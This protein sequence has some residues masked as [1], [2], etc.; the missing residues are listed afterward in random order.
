MEHELSASPAVVE[1]A[2]G[3]GAESVA[4]EHDGEHALSWLA[5]ARI[6]VVALGAA[7]VWLHLWEP[8]ARVSLIGVAGVLI[9]GWPI[10]TEAAENLAARRMTMELS[11][12]IAIIAAAAISEFFTA[13]I[14]TLFVLI[15]EVLENM[16]V[17]RG[18]RAIRDLLEFLPRSVTVRRIDGVREASADE[19]RA[20]DAVLVKPG[21]AVPMDG[22]VISGHSFVDQSRITGES[23]PVEKVAGTPVYAGTINQSGAL[24]IRTERVGRDTSYGKIIEAVEN[25]ERSRAPVQQLADRLAGYLVYFALAAAALTLFITH[26]VRSTISVVIVAGACGI[27]AGTPLAILGGIGRCAR[28]GAII[29]GGLYL[30]TLGK[31]NTVVLDKTGTLTFGRPEVQAVVPRP[32][33]SEAEVLDVAASAEMRS[34]HPLGRAIVARAVAHQRSIREPDRFDYTPG[35]GIT[36]RVGGATILV[37]NRALLSENAVEVANDLPSNIN[38]A[39]EVFVARNGQFLGAIVIADTVRPEARRAIASLHRM[40]I[41]TILLTGDAKPVA[42]AVARELRI[43]DVEAD[44]LPE[45]KLARIKSLVKSCCVVA[46]VGDGIN[47]APALTQA[48]VGVAMGSGT[49]VA[50]ESADVVLLGNDLVRFT[51]T[52]AIARWTRRIIWQNFAG[53]IAV[54]MVGI[55]LAAAGLFNPTLAAFIHVASEMT[56]ILNS[57]RLLPRSQQSAAAAQAPTSR[58]ESLAKA[59]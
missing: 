1:R 39:S 15:A 48:S 10:F 28:L 41:R 58:D 29:K 3:A 11:M 42:D 7:A 30:E 5:A 49:D 19:L 35:L 33:I 47:D 44:L 14:I 2:Q 27:A 32:G 22:I 59:A 20:G 46:M 43:S 57:A 31:V 16:T 40:N 56:F 23:M 55:G 51:E 26:D 54:D 36:A 50:R 6:V 34:E 21:A 18:R 13:L 45:A 38:A 53:T 37:G 17:S 4:E 12:S 8:F 24:E 25:A 9:G 52:L